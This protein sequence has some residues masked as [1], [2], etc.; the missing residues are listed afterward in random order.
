VGS[1]WS[2]C[3][4][5][6]GTCAIGARRCSF[7]GA[8][9]QAKTT[10]APRCSEPC[11]MRN[12]CRTKHQG[13]KTHGMG[14]IHRYLS[15]MKGQNK[16]FSPLECAK[17]QTKS[18]ITP[19]ERKQGCRSA[20]RR[21]PWGSSPSQKQTEKPAGWFFGG[22]SPTWGCLRGRSPFNKGKTENRQPKLSIFEY[23]LRGSNP[24]PAD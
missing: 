16:A 11:T 4:K 22:R 14:R 9:T 6:G 5:R 8:G 1:C 17:P 10:P 2:R 18:V 13:I 20:G 15:S 21:G 19:T 12:R 24:G 3:G 23:T 7:C